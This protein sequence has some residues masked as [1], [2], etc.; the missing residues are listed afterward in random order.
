MAGKCAATSCN[1][2]GFAFCDDFE[3]GAAD[4]WSTSGGAWSVVLDGTRVYKG[5][6]G[7]YNSTAGSIAWT[8][9]SVES[10]MKILA[11]GGTSSSYRAGIIA[12][13][14]G[15]TNYYTLAIDAAGYV[16]LLRGT[17]TPSGASGACGPALTGLAS[18]TNTWVTLKMQVSGPTNN[19]RI[20][21]WLNGTQVHD[22][23][24]TSSTVA[25]GNAGVM[26]YGSSTIAEFDDVRVSTP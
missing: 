26:T 8:D 23:I 22:C 10:K 3:D 5:G 7:P 15:S 24:T 4:G 1:L 13:N 18:L 19:V 17:S 12:R 9:Q 16:R 20:V 11:F 21:T 6:N 2:S 14:A 25:A